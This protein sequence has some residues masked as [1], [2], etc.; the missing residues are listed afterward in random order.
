MKQ[1]S[2]NMLSSF[3]HCAQISLA[4]A[5]KSFMDWF[6]SSEH[7]DSI[8]GEMV[9]WAGEVRPGII[10]RSVHWG[11]SAVGRVIWIKGH[12]ERSKPTPETSL[13]KGENQK[14]I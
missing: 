12:A 7:P 6:F 4:K 8:P 9:G 14:A 11:W 5:Q 1:N 13:K 3:G 2:I 10:W